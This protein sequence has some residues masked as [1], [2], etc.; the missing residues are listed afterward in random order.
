MKRWSTPYVIRKLEIKKQKWYS[1]WKIVWQF[2]IKLNIS[3]LY[4][5]A[6]TILAIKLDEL[7]TFVHTKTY[8]QLDVVAEIGWLTFEASSGK[9][10]MKPSLKKKKKKSWVWQYMPIILATQAAKVGQS[11]SEAGS[12]Q[13]QDLTWKSS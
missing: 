6:N 3:L 9:N 2:L 4:D 7:K 5:Q 13:K 10:T 8:K 12:G 1:L 11:G